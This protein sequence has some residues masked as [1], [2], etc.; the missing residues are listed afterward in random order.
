MK[1]KH[2]SSATSII[3]AKDV[4]ILMDPWIEDGEYYGSWFHYPKI[5]KDKINFAEVTHIYVSHIHP[6]HFSVK[7]FEALNKSIPIYI[8]KYDAKFLKFNLERLG[9]NVFELD[10]GISQK[11]SDSVN[12]TIFAADNCNPELCSKFIGCAPM[13]GKFK[14]TQIDSLAVISD[15]EYNILN[16]NDCPFELSNGAINAVMKKFKHID[17][18]LVGYCGAGPYPQCFEM[19][20]IAKNKAAEEKKLQF[21]NLGLKF[22]NKIK[23]KYYMPFAGTYI[24]GGSLS[25]LNDYR[26]IPELDEALDYYSSNTTDIQSKGILLN[27]NESF[28][29][30]NSI[31]S[32]EYEKVNIEE[33][34]YYINNVLKKVKYKYQQEEFI[35]EDRILE[36]L[37]EAFKRFEAKKNQIGFKSKTLL[38]INISEKSDLLISLNETSTYEIVSNNFYENSSSY[39]RISLDNRLLFKLLKGPRYAHWNNAEIGSHLTFKRYPNIFERGL[40]HCLYFLHL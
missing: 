26:G 27:Q 7:T 36:L 33:R 31:Q 25:N 2:I 24:L 3:E 20:Q 19:D 6:D 37:P 5:N 21:L 13:E 16:L 29:L 15:G 4:K 28:N 39:V 23:P 30:Q 40:Y 11:L 18:M 14:S 10:N 35:T 1:L 34:E 17:L 32:K 8:H 22:I 38:F 9:F 12:I